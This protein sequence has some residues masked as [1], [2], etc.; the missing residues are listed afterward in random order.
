M[1]FSV[2]RVRRELST[3]PHNLF[4]VCLGTVRGVDEIY[5]QAV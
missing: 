5:D 2:V 4:G 1:N 3:A